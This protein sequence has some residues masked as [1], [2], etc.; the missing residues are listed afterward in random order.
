MRAQDFKIGESCSYFDKR[1]YCIDSI[2]EMNDKLIEEDLFISKLDKYN[3]DFIPLKL[4]FYFKKQIVFDGDKDIYDD[5]VLYSS[6]FISFKRCSAQLVLNTILQGNFVSLRIIKIEECSISDPD[7]LQI[8][9]KLDY[10]HGV[11]TNDNNANKLRDHQLEHKNSFT[12]NDV[13]INIKKCQ[14]LTTALFDYLKNWDNNSFTDENNRKLGCAFSINF[15]GILRSTTLLQFSTS[16][17]F[18]QLR[19]L[20]LKNH[21]QYNNSPVLL[22]LLLSSRNFTKRTQAAI[23]YQQKKQ[24]RN[25]GDSD[26]EEE[27]EIED[28]DMQLHS[29][30]LPDDGK[31]TDQIRSNLERLSFDYSVCQNFD[32]LPLNSDYFNNLK[33]ISYDAAHKSKKGESTNE[34]DKTKDMVQITFQNMFPYSLQNLQMLKLKFCSL[35]Y[36]F[37][38]NIEYMKCLQNLQILN[39]SYCF[40]DMYEFSNFIINSGLKNLK[41]LILRATNVDDN[42]C[43][44]VSDIT[45]VS[46]QLEE[47]DVSK[48]KGVS[49]KGVKYLTMIDSLKCLNIKEKENINCQLSTFL[50]DL[51]ER[52]RFLYVKSVLEDIEINKNINLCEE[53]LKEIEKNEELLNKKANQFTRNAFTSNNIYDEQQNEISEQG[54]FQFAYSGQEREEDQNQDED[55]IIEKSDGEQTRKNAEA[56]KLQQQKQ[57][58]SKFEIS[59]QDIQKNNNIKHPRYDLLMSYTHKCPQIVHMDFSGCENVTTPFFEDLYRHRLLNRLTYLNLKGTK[60]DNNL[61]DI[62]KQSCIQKSEGVQ[63]YWVSH[64]F[65]Q[66][67]PIYENQILEVCDNQFIHDSIKFFS[68]RDCKVIRGFKIVFLFKSIPLLSLQEIDLSNCNVF[69][70]TLIQLADEAKEKYPNLT[71]IKLAQVKSS[72]V[73]IKALRKL[74]ANKIVYLDLRSTNFDDENSLMFFSDPHNKLLRTLQFLVVKDCKQLTTTGLQAMVDG[75]AGLDRAEIYNLR[76]N[77]SEQEK[78][79]YQ[80]RTQE[81]QKQ[82]QEELKARIQNLQD[83]IK[84]LE[85]QNKKRKKHKGEV[86]P[87]DKKDK[88][89]KELDDILKK[90]NKQKVRIICETFDVFGLLQDCYQLVTDDL[91]TNFLQKLGHVCKNIFELNLNKMGRLTLNDFEFTGSSQ[92]NEEIDSEIF[93]NLEIMNINE[94]RITTNFVRK[95]F[96]F[97]INSNQD[98]KNELKMKNFMILRCQK[99]YFVNPS[100]LDVFKNQ[101]H[102]RNILS[103]THFK[104]ELLLNELGLKIM[105][106]NLAFLE[107]LKVS[108]TRFVSIN[109]KELNLENNQYISQQGFTT[110]LKSGWMKYILR[111][112]VRNTQFGNTQLEQMSQMMKDKKSQKQFVKLQY[113]GMR[114]CVQVSRKGLMLLCQMDKLNE[115]FDLGCICE[116]KML[117]DA[118]LMKDM[119]Q[120]V[121]C[122]NMEFLD[123]SDN[124]F[125]SIDKGFKY[126]CFKGKDVKLNLKI[127]NVSSTWISDKALQSLAVSENFNQLEKIILKDCKRIT[128]R[129]LSYLVDSKQLMNLDLQFLFSSN[130]QFLSG[131]VIDTLKY[132]DRKKT[133]KEISLLGS[134]AQDKEINNIMQ[135]IISENYLIKTIDIRKTS[136]IGIAGLSYIFSMVQWN[137]V[138]GQ[139]VKCPLQALI[140]DNIR[141]QEFRARY[142][143]DDYM[144]QVQNIPDCKAKEDEFSNIFVEDLKS[145]F[146]S[147]FQ[148]LKGQLTYQEFIKK[149]QDIYN[150]L[151][152]KIR[153][154]SKPQ[155]LNDIFV[156]DFI[157]NLFLSANNLNNFKYDFFIRKFALSIEDQFID[158]LTLC[159]Q[160]FSI[161]KDMESPNDGQQNQTEQNINKF[162]LIG[163]KAGGEQQNNQNDTQNNTINY[164]SFKDQFEYFDIKGNKVLCDVSVCRFFLSSQMVSNIK[165]INISYTLLSE[166][167]V[168]AICASPYLRESLE[169]I[170]FNR[171]PKL[172]VKDALQYLLMTNFKKLR[173]KPLISQYHNYIDDEILTLIL[174]KF[175]PEEVRYLNLSNSRITSM[176]LVLLEHSHLSEYFYL[177]DLKS[178]GIEAEKLDQFMISEENEEKGMPFPKNL[179]YMWLENTY[180]LTDEELYKLKFW[181]CFKSNNFDFMEMVQSKARKLNL[182]LRHLTNIELR[183]HIFKK[184]YIQLD[185]YTYIPSDV[186]ITLINDQFYKEAD[187]FYDLKYIIL[188]F[189]KQQYYALQKCFDWYNASDVEKILA[190]YCIRITKIPSEYQNLPIIKLTNKS[191]DSEQAEVREAIQFDFHNYLTTMDCD[192]ILKV[193]KFVEASLLLKLDF[194]GTDITG[195]F[196]AILCKSIKGDQNR[197][198]E[199]SLKGLKT[200]RDEHIMSMMFDE[201]EMDQMQKNMIEI[202][203]K[204]KSKKLAD[205]IKKKEEIKK[206]IQVQIRKISRFKKFPFLVRL[207]IQNTKVTQFSLVQILNLT[208]FNMGFRIEDLFDQYAKSEYTKIDDHTINAL[209]QSNYLQ[210]FKVLNL[211]NILCSSNT[212]GKLLRSPKA[213]NIQEMILNTTNLSE[214]AFITLANSTNLPRL[215]QIKC[216]QDTNPAIRKSYHYIMRA[217]Y[218]SMNLK[219]DEIMKSRDVMDTSQFIQAIMNSFYMNNLSTIEIH[220]ANQFMQQIKSLFKMSLFT[221]QITKVC[222]QDVADSIEY[223]DIWQM[224]S[225]SKSFPRLQIL[226]VR[227]LKEKEHLIILLNQ[228]FK[229]Q[230]DMESL[231]KDNKSLIDDD[232]IIFISKMPLLLNSKEIDLSSLNKISVKAWQQFANS[233]YVINLNKINF[234]DGTLLNYKTDNN[235]ALRKYYFHPEVEFAGSSKCFGLFSQNNFFNLEKIDITNN[236]GLPIEEIKYILMSIKKRHVSVKFDFEDI[237]IQIIDDIRPLML[238]LTQEEDDDYSDQDEM[239]D[240]DQQYNLQDQ[241]WNKYLKE[242]YELFQ[243]YFIKDREWYNKRHK[244]LD[245]T[246]FQFMRHFSSFQDIFRQ[247]SDLSCIE[248]IKFYEGGFDSVFSSNNMKFLNLKNVKILNLEGDKKLAQDY[249]GY[250]MKMIMEQKYIK[251]Y[252]FNINGFLDNYYMNERIQQQLIKK[253]TYILCQKELKIYLYFITKEQIETIFNKGDIHYAATTITLLDKFRLQIHGQTA[254]AYEEDDQMDQQE[255][256][257]QL[258]EKQEYFIELLSQSNSFSQITKIDTPLPLS[259]K[260]IK[261]LLKSKCLSHSFDFQKHVMDLEVDQEYFDLF[262][263]SKYFKSQTKIIIPRLIQQQKQENQNAKQNAKD[264]NQTSQN[265]WLDIQKLD[266]NCLERLN[267]IVVLE[268]IKDKDFLTKLFSIENVKF[269]RDFTCDK[270][271]I[272]EIDQNQF[273]HIFEQDWPGMDWQILLDLLEK[274]KASIDGE[275]YEKLLLNKSAHFFITQIIIPETLTE[276]KAGDLI[277]SINKS[278][279]KTQQKLHI[280]KL[281]IRQ[282]PQSNQVEAQ[283]ETHKNDQAS[284]IKQFLSSVTNLKYIEFSSKVKFGMNE[285]MVLINNTRNTDLSEVV[286]SWVIPKLSKQDLEKFLVCLMNDR[287]IPYNL[288]YISFKQNPHFYSHKALEQQINELRSNKKAKK[289]ENKEGQEQQLEEE[290]DDKKEIEDKNEDKEEKQDDGEGPKD[291]GE[292]HESNNQS[293]NNIEENNQENVEGQEQ[294]QD[295]KQVLKE[296]DSLLKNSITED[297]LVEFLQNFKGLRE[298]DFQGTNFDIHHLKSLKTLPLIKKFHFINFKDCKSFTDGIP[299]IW[300]IHDDSKPWF[301]FQKYLSNLPIEQITNQRQM[302]KAIFNCK[303]FKRHL[304]YFDVDF[305]LKRYQETSKDLV[306]LFSYIIKMRVPNLDITSFM[307]CLPQYMKVF[308]NDNHIEQICK[309]YGNLLY[310]QPELFPSVEYGFNYILQQKNIPTAIRLMYLLNNTFQKKVSAAS[311]SII[312]QV[313]IKSEELK[314]KKYILENDEQLEKFFV[315]YIKKLSL[316]KSRLLKKIQKSKKV[317]DNQQDKKNMK[318]LQALGKKKNIKRKTTTKSKTILDTSSKN[319]DKINSQKNQNSQMQ[320]GQNDDEEEE[321]IKIVQQNIKSNLQDEEIENLRLENGDD[322]RQEYEQLNQNEDDQNQDNENEK[323]EENE[324]GEEEGEGENN[325]EDDLNDNENQDGNEE[326]NDDNDNNNDEDKDNDGFKIQKSYLKDKNT[327]QKGSSRLNSLRNSRVQSKNSLR[328]QDNEQVNEDSEQKQLNDESERVQELLNKERKESLPQT[329]ME[330]FYKTPNMEKQKSRF[331]TTSSNKKIKYNFEGKIQA[332]KNAVKNNL[333]RVYENQT[334]LRL[335]RQLINLHLL[336]EGLKSQIQKSQIYERKLKDVENKLDYLEFELEILRYNKNNFFALEVNNLFNFFEV[337]NLGQNNHLNIYGLNYYV[338]EHIL[339]WI[340]MNQNLNEMKDGQQRKQ[341]ILNY[342]KNKDDSN[343]DDFEAVNVL[344]PDHSLDDKLIEQLSYLIEKRLKQ[345]R[346]IDLCGLN[347][348]D[349]FAEKFS[350]LL[351]DDGKL[352]YLTLLDLTNNRR[353]SPFGLKFLFSSIVNRIPQ[354]FRI[355]LSSTS[356]DSE[357]LRIQIELLEKSILKEAVYIIEQQKKEVMRFISKNKKKL[358][359]PVPQELIKRPSID[360]DMQ[361]DNKHEKLNMEIKDLNVPVI[362]DIFSD[363]NEKKEEEIIDKEVQINDYDSIDSEEERKDRLKKGELQFFFLKERTLDAKIVKKLEKSKNFKQKIERLRN[364][365]LAYTK[366]IQESR[367]KDIVSDNTDVR[368][369]VQNIV[370]LG[371]FQSIN[372]F[373]RDNWKRHK[374]FIIFISTLF[375]PFTIFHLMMVSTYGI[376]LFIQKNKISFRCSFGRSAKNQIKIELDKLVPENIQSTDFFFD[377]D[378]AQ[379]DILLSR[380]NTKKMP[381]DIARRNGRLIC[382][383]LNNPSKHSFQATYDRINDNQNHE[384]N[385]LKYFDFIIIFNFLI[386]TVF[387]CI[388][389]TY[390]LIF[391]YIPNHV[392]Q[393]TCGS[394]PVLYDVPFFAVGLFIVAYEATLLYNIE[395]VIVSKNIFQFKSLFVLFQLYNS[396]MQRYNLYTDMIFAFNTIYCKK[397]TDLGF[398]SISVLG[399]HLVLQTFY[400]F[401][402]IFSIY[403]A[404]QKIKKKIPVH[405]T[406]F[407]NI[408][409]KIALIQDFSGLSIVLDRF[410]TSSTI[411]LEGILIPKQLE[412]VKVPQILL[413]KFQKVFLED[414]PQMIIVLIFNLRFAQT[415]NLLDWQNL[416]VL[417][418]TVLS[419]Y[420]SLNSAW[421]A[422]PSIFRTYQMQD[423]I[424][425]RQDIS[426]VYKI[427]I[428]QNDQDTFNYLSIP[429][430]ISKTLYFNQKYKI[431]KDLKKEGS[432]SQKSR[433]KEQKDRDAQS[434]KGPNSQIGSQNALSDNKSVAQSQ[435]SIQASEQSIKSKVSS[436]GQQQT[437]KSS[438]SND[439]SQKELPESEFKQKLIQFLLEKEQQN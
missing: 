398:A 96:S 255:L 393:K 297:Y 114:G 427:K 362:S 351:S 330:T 79:E 211:E 128:E 246:Y 150:E 203:Q 21:P 149:C 413:T 242:L 331:D 42:F 204:H 12:F 369:I 201:Q 396:F 159:D 48:T 372:I 121:Y 198:T 59:Q 200:V 236:R 174:T 11:S 270:F 250:Q 105:D 110:I 422:H 111:L 400:L 213:I 281:V 24:N 58:E 221:Q 279:R 140:V 7:F 227:S 381:N 155:K 341:K 34:K 300:L 19:K 361:N 309:V 308:V 320:R 433:K 311:L 64:S 183:P 397:A 388:L 439:K 241:L 107:G 367:N 402:A 329:D 357:D 91:F 126:L 312:Y 338:A 87:S 129:G 187:Q 181:K 380:S 290:E 131:R 193:N 378:V 382:E 46:F 370:N 191:L 346:Q 274:N 8:T 147:K 18:K 303:F 216:V 108:E 109:I 436:K 120:S 100:C 13:E 92:G 257:N 53:R 4:S 425:F 395:K 15:M 66:Y 154:C 415:T 177:L 14:Y 102:L 264:N 20:K 260:S 164:P 26:D 170:Y 428:S 151:R 323:E 317:F 238:S 365:Q 143:Y 431:K 31:E 245:L 232:V 295:N 195:H 384:I 68:L 310:L 176:G 157:Q 287:E 352:K 391:Y 55:Q 199:V 325:D 261:Q 16:Q 86:Y 172:K 180:N 89:Q 412:N 57:Q 178:T 424:N 80:Q 229:P 228:K 319:L 438:K 27:E 355:L 273:K 256:Q 185:I 363:E 179:R 267:S 406:T 349:D 416:R 101:K 173:Y 1:T 125:Q 133:I 217:Q 69:D 258:K 98:K 263:S 356:N 411:A 432:S 282:F 342:L 437:K 226:N 127:I 401:S 186:L 254:E 60:V 343:Q 162:A 25:N 283:D 84:Q 61:I 209:S 419:M 423:Y 156:G 253:D 182:T 294:D 293:Q 390:Y 334:A 43:S 67:E 81:K 71:K 207:N 132:S 336:S 139:S 316:K 83:Q 95:F 374:L 269:N 315:Q 259:L 6:S 82:Q 373:V 262:V 97:W 73:G 119:A 88:L 163:K 313:A 54:R 169:A 44:V 189:R 161:F 160:K 225:V 301:Q 358:S 237:F 366:A 387:I 41:S 77:V 235:I 233:K 144:K 410:S 385:M 90:K 135:E 38:S 234:S 240:Q 379:V 223:K 113:I 123:L 418:T 276:E 417:V 103:K 166:K 344:N 94:T 434:S 116:L 32:D 146:G 430:V 5:F 117:I 52:K 56:Q 72:P 326:N 289:T 386:F 45:I 167:V 23:S 345:L 165:I 74:P 296:I 340:K 426:E 35:Q 130:T 409:T 394:I 28:E 239:N 252:L 278:C 197:I 168:L 420:N 138:K 284:E 291:E 298:I 332:Y 249:S 292:A 214:D 318:I 65:K 335:H 354:G 194:Q 142:C 376:F 206:E 2:K 248:T 429:K 364:F 51:L 192:H 224:I 141:Y 30:A 148:P 158:S 76:F 63:E 222:L 302:L 122:K 399:T 202:Y 219:T 359:K 152:H 371:L 106:E 392:S 435:K 286:I 22:E 33:S 137:I 403:E 347:V 324:D 70:N 145:E 306:D 405:N 288:S 272:K 190:K 353:I 327:Q 40:L 78:L 29:D 37:F 247:I 404:K 115:E 220:N 266:L 251:P 104:L 36:K 383:Y 10:Y 299:F 205:S 49:L 337:L 50:I 118:D 407:I 304:K 314:E 244:T 231:L 375:F 271:Q 75:L 17:F 47:I 215:E 360:I 368:L 348:S 184:S 93:K 275:V 339:P 212:L 322:E 333:V 280:N 85:K 389:Y 153:F 196:F 171:C 421:Q 210:N 3:V 39:F 408:Y 175:R 112:N 414:I 265:T 124:G 285:A 377:E 134:Q 218:L 268:P 328:N 188:A 230:F 208:P 243:T 321:F 277:S 305:I 350:L 9:Q 99:A 62:F 136:N 307:Q